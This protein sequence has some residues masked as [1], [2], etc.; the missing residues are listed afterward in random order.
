MHM[1]PY[2]PQ[3]AADWLT[4]TTN[5]SDPT[6]ILA[7]LEK[8]Y[9]VDPAV[10]KAI[11]RKRLEALK[12]GRRRVAEYMMNFETIVCD[13]PEG[14]ELSDNTLKSIFFANLRPE[15]RTALIG[16]IDSVHTW[17]NLAAEVMTRESVLRLGNDHFLFQT[18]AAMAPAVEPVPLNLNEPTPMEIGAI[19]TTIKAVNLLL[20]IQE[21][22]SSINGLVLVL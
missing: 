6:V 3:E 17:K 7:Q 14:H 4:R 8:I 1:L 9:G 2:L 5:L 12:Q 20:N 15:L 19:A 13:F 18:A 16:I 22:I 10:Q 11:C 21:M